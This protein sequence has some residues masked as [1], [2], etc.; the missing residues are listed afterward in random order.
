[1]FASASLREERVEGVIATPNGFVRWHLTIRLNA[2]LEAE[3]LPARIANLDTSLSKVKA[4]DLTHI[5]KVCKV[6]K[7]AAKV[8]RQ[9]AQ[10]GSGSVA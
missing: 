4:E 3:K 9:S 1:M 5:C 8:V 7:K 6:E 10:S 2:V